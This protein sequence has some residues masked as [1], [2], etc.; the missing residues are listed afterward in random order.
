MGSASAAADGRLKR[1][2]G[3]PLKLSRSSRP[4]RMLTAMAFQDLLMS[5]MC[6]V[7]SG[8]SFGV[9]RAYWYFVEVYDGKRAPLLSTL[10]LLRSVQAPR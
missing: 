6:T 5:L 1:F 10:L 4:R 8:Q 7:R 2:R 3:V 9:E